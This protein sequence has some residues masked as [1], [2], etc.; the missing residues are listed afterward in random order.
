[1]AKRCSQVW[2]AEILDMSP[3]ELVNATGEEGI[4]A[5]HR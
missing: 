2:G 3:T 5:L 4:H 1:M